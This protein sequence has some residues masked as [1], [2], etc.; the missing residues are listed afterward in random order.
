M[1]LRPLIITFLGN[2]S[3][4]LK[5]V[6]PPSATRWRREHLEQRSHDCFRACARLCWLVDSRFLSVHVSPSCHFFTF[7][8]KTYTQ[9]PL[10][11]LRGRRRCL[12]HSYR[13]AH[14]SRRVTMV[15]N[16]LVP[17]RKLELL[18][19]CWKLRKGGAAPGNARR[20]CVRARA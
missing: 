19:C 1:F 8:A 20:A 17:T 3:N 2:N 7:E 11:H 9:T 10:I 13:R 12:T 14:E 5:G 15:T 4:L 18:L 6:I 16:D